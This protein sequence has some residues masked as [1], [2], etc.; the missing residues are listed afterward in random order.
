MKSQQ[1]MSQSGAGTEKGIPQHK[2]PTVCTCND[3]ATLIC[4]H[5]HVVSITE[6]FAITSNY[7]RMG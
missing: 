2:K 7:S 5:I 4:A 3:S 1:N 6:C